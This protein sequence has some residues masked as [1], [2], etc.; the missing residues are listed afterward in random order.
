MV[1]TL[2]CGG[3]S[4]GNASNELQR[5]HAGDL[6]VV[7]LSDSDALKQGKSSFVLEFRRG[8]ALVD[9]GTVRVGATM[10]MAG[11]APMFGGSQVRASDTKGRYAIDTD[12]GMAGAWRFNVDWDGPA[13]KGTASLS[14]TVR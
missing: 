13:G 2:A 6:D 4:G 11:M 5:A 3:A 12:L 7:L 8:N 14:Q 1:V 9:V 10:P